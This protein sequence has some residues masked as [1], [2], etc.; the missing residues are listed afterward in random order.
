MGEPGSAGTHSCFMVPFQE[1]LLDLFMF[2]G[3]QLCACARARAR[4]HVPQL[5]CAGVRPVAL[6]SSASLSSTGAYLQYL[7][8]DAADKIGGDELRQLIIILTAAFRSHLADTPKLELCSPI[9]SFN[10]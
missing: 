8:K 10:L 6:I 4:V 3:S 7:Q 9:C 1:E 2:T 5:G